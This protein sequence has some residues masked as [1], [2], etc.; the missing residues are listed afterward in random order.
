MN[1]F[2]L[3]MCFLL[4]STAGFAQQKPHYTQYIMNQYI[5]NPAITGIENYIDIKLSHRHQWVGFDGAPVTTYLTLHKPIGKSDYRTTATSFAMDGEN[6]RGKSYW[7]QYT[8]A[9]PHHGV[10]FQVINDKTG[11]IN[12]FTANVSYAY[13]LGLSPK[14]NL[15]AGFA[16]GVTNISLMAS[17]LDIYP[18]D[19]AV[20]A[21]KE[22]RKLR[23]DISAGLYLY[24]ADYF[25]GLSV[26]QVVPQT[27]VFKE[28]GVKKENARLVPHLFATAGY[29]FSV[30]YDFNLVPSLMIKYIQQP[31]FEVNAKLQYQDK[32][33]TGL[34]YRQNDAVA[35][36][37]GL[38]VSNTFNLSYSYDYT[39]NP[40]KQFLRNTHELMI[41]FLIGNRYGDSCPRNVW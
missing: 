6:P 1:N 22:L 21:T 18:V 9:Q 28:G 29:R 16:A 12:R 3:G 23:P 34:S 25:A 32:A 20:Y 27:V 26:Q 13:H 40:G 33:W 37:V 35:G 2:V 19:P 36:M 31:Q 38:N 11:P 14:T 8:A 17:K 10:G 39:T 41:G 7:E 4:F 15:S 5:I 30:G 24:S